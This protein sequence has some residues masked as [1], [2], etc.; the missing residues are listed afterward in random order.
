M[1]QVPERALRR[2]CSIEDLKYTGIAIDGEGLAKL[3][4][5]GSVV[6]ELESASHVPHG[7]GGFTDS[8]AACW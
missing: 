4:L 6:I 3:G 5:D 8:A 7:Q 1:V 2:T